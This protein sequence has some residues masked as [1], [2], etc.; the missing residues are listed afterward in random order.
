[1]LWWL[2]SSLMHSLLVA[3]S[4]SSA[5]WLALIKQ[6]AIVSVVDYEDGT[7]AWLHHHQNIK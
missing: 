1:M 4:S 7:C 6:P 3:V 2:Q 5:L